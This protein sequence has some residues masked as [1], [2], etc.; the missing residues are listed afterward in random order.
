[1]PSTSFPPDTA[2]CGPDGP[3]GGTKLAV[4]PPT[5]QSS[6]VGAG[7]SRWSSLP[8]RLPPLRRA[9]ERVLCPRYRPTVPLWL[10]FAALPNPL[11]RYAAVA[12]P[13][14]TPFG[15]WHFPRGA[16]GRLTSLTRW[17]VGATSSPRRRRPATFSRTLL[18]PA[19]M[20]CR[21]WRHE[22]YIAPARQCR[23]LPGRNARQQEARYGM[24][25]HHEPSRAS[26]SRGTGRAVQ[27]LAEQLYP[28][29]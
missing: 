23:C 17:V 20:E 15:V 3:H 21:R 6:G 27:V 28:A 22:F 2:V 16:R 13:C 10:W 5:R 19:F 1:M 12:G 8:P 29:F 4:R 24:L 26:Q 18:S 7:L 14:L 11:R 25:A 9:S